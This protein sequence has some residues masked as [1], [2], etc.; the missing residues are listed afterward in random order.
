[1]TAIIC[2][3]TQRLGV[4]LGLAMLTLA[5]GL[6]T[7]AAAADGFPKSADDVLV[8]D[9]L[10]PGQVRRVGKIKGFLTARRPARLPQFECAYRGGEYVAYDR[11]TLA[12]S[13]QAWSS[14]AEGGDVE[15]MNILGE[16]YAKGLGQAPDY[17]NARTWFERAAAAGSRKAQQN[18]G[19]LY[20]NGLGVPADRERA[21]SYFRKALDAN[22][23]ALVYSSDALRAAELR[24]EIEELRS[25][26]QRSESEVAGLRQ[27]LVERSAALD[28]SVSAMR[29]LRKQYDELKRK[30]TD[31]AVEGV[32]RVLEESIKER[33]REISAQQSEI[34]KLRARSGSVVSEPY[35]QIGPD[36]TLRLDR[37]VI[38][39]ARGRP[40]ALLKSADTSLSL[41]GRAI[42]ADAVAAIEVD[43]QQVVIDG[44][45]RFEV[46]LAGL[47]EREVTVIARARGGSETRADFLLLPPA[48]NGT[49]TPLP[50][51]AR[52]VPKAMRSGA[53]KALLVAISGYQTYPGLPTPRADAD[54]LAAVLRDRFGFDV[55]VIAD[56]TRLDLLLAL[57]TFRQS[58]ANEDSGLIYFA[59]HGE[60]DGQQQGYWIPSDGQRDDPKT[61]I[62][63]RVITDMLA[64]S[65][66]RH[67]L[68]VAD[69]CYSGTLTRV[70]AQPPTE[71]L[72]AEQ[73]QAWADVSAAGRS[74]VAIT[75]GGLRPV[76]ESSSGTVST[77]ASALAR[78]LSD[79]QGALE[80][81]RLFRELRTRI[82]SDPVAQ[83]FAQR[84]EMAPLQFAGHE[85][86]ELFFVPR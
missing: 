16:A 34:E 50:I 47:S 75:S 28:A 73:W 32:W 79:A 76:P 59:G 2:P 3:I 62:A 55:Q 1:M 46:A 86:G 70:A 33:E 43:G 31:V 30:S 58:L 37:P 57:H 25:Q 44:E 41:S 9:C 77:F 85:R 61:W 64:V 72:P 12:S 67:L 8:V 54:L 71:L 7:P 11:V 17:A 4:V 26:Q 10:L 36:L 63:N 40:V 22:A 23:E 69:S 20:E 18:L 51:A 19:H 66:A 21:L 45:G 80:A 48:A 13:V 35:V 38:L 29:E 74:R 84:P 14:S 83:S 39:A 81:Q 53:Q 68:V 65:D 27:Q 49:A 15:A 24:S 42:P 82:A 56:P 6:P 60:I 5:S 78:V 52:P